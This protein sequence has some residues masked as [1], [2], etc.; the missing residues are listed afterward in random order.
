M[1]SMAVAERVVSAVF[2]TAICVGCSADHVADHRDSTPGH[3]AKH[4]TS[5]DGTTL[6]PPTTDKISRHANMD[7]V[8]EFEPPGVSLDWK[9]LVLHHSAT[10]GGSVESVDAGHRLR[11]DQF[12][13][14]WLGIGYHFV[15]GN[16]HGMPDGQVEPTFRWREQLPG[17]HA[18]SREHNRLGIGICLIGN[19]DDALPTPRQIAAV[20]QLCHWLIGRYQIPCKRVLR[21]LDVAATSCPGRLFPYAQLIDELDIRPLAVAATVDDESLR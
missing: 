2:V 12:G 9:Y 10:D 17:A 8:I 11:K 14:P 6:R 16:G 13:N 4:S 18:G 21:H 3:V 1:L 5:S 15:V 7:D 19:F 20:R